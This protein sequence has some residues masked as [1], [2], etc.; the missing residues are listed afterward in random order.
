MERHK[1]QRQDS[2]DTIK[3]PSHQTIDCA[4]FHK[5]C[6]LADSKMILLAR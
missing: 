5:F 3:T 2:E 1:K 4:S 6:L